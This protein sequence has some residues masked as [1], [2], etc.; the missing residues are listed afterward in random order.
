MMSSSVIENSS[1]EASTLLMR[2]ECVSSAP[3]GV[4]VVPDV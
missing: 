2:F 1:A 3:F 4:P